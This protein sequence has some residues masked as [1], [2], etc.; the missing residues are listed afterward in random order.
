MSTKA[1]PFGSLTALLLTI[2]ALVH[3]ARVVFSVDVVEGGRPVSMASCV[4][5]T[6]V[7]GGR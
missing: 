5:A 4:V 1:R 7:A 2:V 3:P 6:I